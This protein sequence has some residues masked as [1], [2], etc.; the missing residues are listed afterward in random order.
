VL[1]LESDTSDAPKAKRLR[2]LEE[3]LTQASCALDSLD[4]DGGVASREER[5]N[6]LD[7]CNALDARITRLRNMVLSEEVT[8][9]SSETVEGCTG[10][11]R[12]S[13][14]EESHDVRTGAPES[15]QSVNSEVVLENG[16]VDAAQQRIAEAE[17]LRTEGNTAFKAEDYAFAVKHYLAALH[18]DGE[19]VAILSNLAAAEL[20]LGEFESAIVHATAANDLSG[21][22][23]AKALFRKGQALEGLHRFVDACEA[24]QSAL[25]IEPGDKLVRQRLQSC[26]KA[27]EDSL[28][29]Q[30]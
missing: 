29:A 22:F 19:N 11:V 23:S 20:K 25:S 6:E 30:A 3:N 21:G 4:V 15:Q 24:Y 28:A 27:N 16:E 13:S 8:I 17:R 12:G 1:R 14:V 9:S 10:S 2:I 5:R 7:R 18:L 26:R